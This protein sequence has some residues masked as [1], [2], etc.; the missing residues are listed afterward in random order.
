LSP[1]SGTASPLFPALVKLTTQT[2]IYGAGQ[3]VS[4][5]LN[6]LLVPF[7]TNTFTSAEYGKLGVI[8]TFIGL[9]EVLFAFGMRQAILRF[10]NKSEH[11]KKAVFSAGVLVI[12]MASFVGFILFKQI[13]PYFISNL[14]LGSFFLYRYILTILILDALSVAPYA[15]L[16]SA[17]KAGRFAI[18]RIAH[19]TIYLIT[20]L[21]FVLVRH[22]TNV[23]VILLANI[24][25]SAMI[26]LQFI[27][28][29][30]KNLTVS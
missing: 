7:L 18:C 2:V 27:P 10:D 29:Y 13:A 15:R 9:A 5:G 23:E 25:A 8:Q 4:R 30:L 26:V 19:V 14:A 12:L 3:V 21:Y 16:Q 24:V 11:S 6:F 17:G 22:R 1:K 28:I 20:C